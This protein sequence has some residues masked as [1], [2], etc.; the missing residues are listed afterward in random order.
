MSFDGVR[1]P[2]AEGLP[3]ARAYLPRRQPER[4]PATLAALRTQLTW[5]LALR[6][7][8]RQKPLMCVGVTITGYDCKM[9]GRLRQ[10]WRTFLAA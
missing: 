10:L 9:R 3:C 7:P 6:L 8:S 1:N 4:R 5:I 2:D